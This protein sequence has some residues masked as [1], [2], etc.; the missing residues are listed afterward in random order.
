ML[1]THIRMRNGFWDEIAGVWSAELRAAR[2]AARQGSF[3]LAAAARGRQGAAASAAR[4][5][6]DSA[7]ALSPDKTL[8][9][10]INGY[11]LTRREFTNLTPKMW[12]VS[13]RF[14]TEWVLSCLNI[15]W[16]L[17]WRGGESCEYCVVLVLLWTVAAMSIQKCLLDNSSRMIKA[18]STAKAGT[19]DANKT[20]R[21]RTG[22]MIVYF[23]TI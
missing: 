7:R 23:W 14:R 9:R 15:Y 6:T 20:V 16:C 2:V 17:L 18:M 19:S 13:A 4:T 10:Q 5:A 1:C 11:N 22:D 8:L 21:F 12:C 3:V